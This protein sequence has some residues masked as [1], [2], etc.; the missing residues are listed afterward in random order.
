MPY[1]WG[2]QF[3]EDECNPSLSYH[4]FYLTRDNKAEY[5]KMIACDVISPSQIWLQMAK[6][7]EDLSKLMFNLK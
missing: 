3:S 2:E 7:K 5:E 6:Q 4:P 1:L